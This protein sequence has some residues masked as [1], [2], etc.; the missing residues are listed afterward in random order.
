MS[1]LV[2]ERDTHWNDRL[3]QWYLDMLLEAQKSSVVGE[4]INMYD[5]YSANPKKD[6]TVVPYMDTNYFIAEFDN[7]I[8]NIKEGKNGK[9]GSVDAKT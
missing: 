2:V 5:L 6:A 1:L 4:V 7:I 8:K 3:W 9:K